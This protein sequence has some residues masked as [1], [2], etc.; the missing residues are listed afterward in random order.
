MVDWYT[1][2]V[3]TVCVLLA[4]TGI[5]IINRLFDEKKKKNSLF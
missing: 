1:G 4:Y 2:L 3:V 5:K